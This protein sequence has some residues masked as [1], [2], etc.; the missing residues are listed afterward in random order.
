VNVVAPIVDATA[1]VNPL[2]EMSAAFDRVMVVLQ[3]RPWFPD[4]K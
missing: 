4:E 3:L 2:P 1:A